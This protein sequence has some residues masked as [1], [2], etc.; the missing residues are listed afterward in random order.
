[1]L[2]ELVKLLVGDSMDWSENFAPLLK[3]TKARSAFQKLFHVVV[4]L[5]K[6]FLAFLVKINSPFA[7]F[8]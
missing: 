8:V 3:G 1:M 7:E 6:P 2:N 5:K 4:F